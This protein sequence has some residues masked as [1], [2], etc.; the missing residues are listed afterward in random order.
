MATKKTEIMN[1]VT[2]ETSAAVETQEQPVDP[3]KQMVPLYIPRG[4]KNEENF[5]LISL[6]GK[7]W[8]IMKG[9]Q[10][11]VPRPVYDVW[12]ESERMKNRQRNYEDQVS[13]R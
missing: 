7:V 3:M 6:N 2:E 1:E 8:K 12:A 5:E 13:A 9:T 10:V 4:A 11:Q